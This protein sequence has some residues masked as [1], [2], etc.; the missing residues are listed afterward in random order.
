MITPADTMFRFVNMTLTGIAV[1]LATAA[2]SMTHDADPG[3]DRLLLVA[4]VLLVGFASAAT[5]ALECPVARC[6]LQVVHAVSVAAAS[7]AAA[8]ALAWWISALPPVGEILAID[9]AASAA[10]LAALLL[11]ARCR[12]TPRVVVVGINDFGIATAQRLAAD[13]RRVRMMG[14]I[15][16]GPPGRTNAALPFPVLASVGEI[17]TGRARLPADM[18]VVALPQA[19]E[20]DIAGLRRKLGPV[21]ADVVVATP[22]LSGNATQRGTEGRIGGLK[23]M[24]LGPRRLSPVER[25]CKRAFDIAVASMALVLM[26]PVMIACAI[27]I[28]LESPGPII[29]R[30]RRYTTDGRLFV[31][32][33]FRS[34]RSDPEPTSEIR[35]TERNDSRVTR[36]GAVLRRTSLDELPQFLN[37]LEG[38]MSVVGPRPHPPGVKVGD[39]VY[40]EVIANFSDRY[41]VK[42]GITGWAQVSGLRGNTFTE[43]H[44]EERFSADLEYIRNWC[45]S[46]EILIVVKTVFGGFVGKNAF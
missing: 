41:V 6:Q 16:D 25:A 20:D 21:R 17:A 31:L 22:L 8:V 34:M 18:I 7:T 35:L 36:V 3:L 28:R 46:L 19:T 5:P 15:D 33:K 39:R 27:A 29:Y 9:G 42:P 26:A 44:L 38:H 2:W 43:Q 13:P 24:A 4:M 11:T 23:V 10:L 45:L 32:Y 1:F 12:R 40:E 37:V 30:Q 14:F